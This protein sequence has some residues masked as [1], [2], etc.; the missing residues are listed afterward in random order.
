[1]KTARLRI[2]SVRMKDGGAELHIFRR[3]DNNR[4]LAGFVKN[5]DMIAECR[6][7]MCGYAIVAWERDGSSSVVCATTGNPVPT[8]LV[9]EFVKTAI[10]DF[11]HSQPNDD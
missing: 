8:L 10:A 1:M 3:D 11:I 4:I 6:P 2:R 5:S 9:P 7:D